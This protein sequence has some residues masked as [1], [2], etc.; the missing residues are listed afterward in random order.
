MK[1]IRTREEKKEKV[2]HCYIFTGAS[3]EKLLERKLNTKVYSNAYF[4][5]VLIEADNWNDRLSPWYA[6]PVFGRE[7]FGGKG[8][9]TLKWL[10]DEVILSVEGT[11]WK[12]NRRIIGGYSL[13][14]LFSLWAFYETGLFEGAVSCSGSLWYPGWD[15]YMQGRNGPKGGRVYLSL[16][17]TEEKTKNQQMQKVG[18]RTRRQLEILQADRNI[19]MATLE[20]NPG[21]H[22]RDAEERL[23]KG[24]LWMQEAM[25]ETTLLP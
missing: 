19:S 11:Q 14:G 15:K 20:W 25:Q 23:A 22:F 17:D 1:I 3:N 13:A 21:G 12:E 5:I 7:G 8:P 2:K 9:E 16:G 6:P 18:E 10:Q 24:I 4:N